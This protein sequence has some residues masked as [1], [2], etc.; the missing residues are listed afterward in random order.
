MRKLLLIAVTALTACL[1]VWGDDWPSQGGNP[2]RDGWAKY[3]KGF[4]KQNVGGLQLL[5]TYQAD[6]QAKGLNALTAPLVNGLLITYR[7]FKEMLVFGGSSDTV[8]SVDADLNRLI[9]KTQLPVKA[10]ASGEEKH[11][12]SCPGGLT[13]AL[14]MPGSSTASG[15]GNGFRRVPVPVTP[16]G[17]LP[18]KPLPP[19]TLPP[20]VI[21]PKP[22][23]LATGFG[24]PGAFLAVGSDG[25]LHVLNTSTGAD[26]VP[27]IPFLPAGANV[28][29]LNIS[30]DTVYAAT[31]GDCGGNPNALYAADLSSD[32]PKIA[33][34]LTNGAGPAGTLGTAIDK[35]GTVYAQ[36]SSGRGELAG[37]YNNSVV[38]LTSKTLAE[39]DYFT[40]ESKQNAVA[41]GATPM[42][43]DWKGKEL[44]LAAGGDGSLYLL[45][46]AS[47][48][49]A[50]HHQPLSKTDPVANGFRGG[51]ASWEDTATGTRWVYA[52]LG[53]PALS[54]AHFPAENG[55]AA[56]GSVLAFTVQEQSG[57]PAL[58]PAW[59]SRD[60]IAPAP[61]VIANGIVFAL[62]GGD[63]NNKKNSHAVLYALDAATGKELYSSQS[64]IRSFSHNGGLAIANRRIYFT[65]HDNAVYCFGFFAD[66][67]QLTGR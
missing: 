55:K 36:I 18:L 4:T 10:Q 41:S 31:S 25:S 61:V 16:A 35:N 66:Q 59:I 7:G 50:D 48:G 15:R 43:F 5:Y 60:M 24:R 9:W 37:A 44:L 34:F 20:S 12:D 54:S 22:G 47:L 17:A 28:S 56:H 45:N 62:A 46:P 40:P 38:A 21:P 8:Y 67:L 13:A 53:G 29:S 1:I 27:P 11:A 30:N 63:S 57:H 64:L 14:A 65:T 2:Q 51:F 42:V 26:R 52:S 58:V 39:K 33:S 23:L 49:G 3:E 19:V 6:N 32:T